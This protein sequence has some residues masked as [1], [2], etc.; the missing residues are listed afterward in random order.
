VR[1]KH[2]DNPGTHAPEIILASASPRRSEI[3]SRI[4]DKFTIVT[5]N[6]VERAEGSPEEQALFLAEA[7]ARAVA[8]EHPG[9][10]IGADTIVVIDEHVLG[11]PGSREQARR[12]LEMLSGRAH[13]VLTGLCV[14]RTDRDTAQLWCEKTTVHFRD[15][16]DREI[17]RYI[18]TEEYIDKAG[19]YAIQ[20][21]AAAFIS[22]IEGDYFNVMGLPLC[23]LVLLLRKTGVDLL[24]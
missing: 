19:G 5:S 13:D 3:L 21:Y 14:L 8:A 16:S 10:V 11:K 22:G 4:T 17:D 15:L 6:V 20:G 23:R 2:E 18:D 12:M 9:V 7:K 1:R 24:S